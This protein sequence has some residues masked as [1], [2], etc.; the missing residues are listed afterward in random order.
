MTDDGPFT[1]D[2]LAE[3]LVSHRL[4]NARPGDALAADLVRVG[5][6]VMALTR[7]YGAYLLPPESLEGLCGALCRALGAGACRIHL[8]GGG[9]GEALTLR[10]DGS[11]EACAPLG[12]GA[13]TALSSG[14]PVMAGDRLYAPLPEGDGVIELSGKPE[15]FTGEDVFL[16]V[17]TGR[18]VGAHARRVIG[19]GPEEAGP[20]EE[21]VVAG[22]DGEIRVDAM[23][24]SIL[25]MAIEM[26][27]ADRGSILI[28]D[29]VTATLN[30]RA[31]VGLGAG[32]I[33]LPV[34]RGLAGAVF[35]TG[36]AIVCNDAHA[37]IR[38]EPAA[39]R[40]TGYRTRAMLC[41]PV[42]ASERGR[43]GVLTVINKRSGEFTRAD[44]RRLKVL[45]QQIGVAL[46]HERMF[47]RMA[48]VTTYNE[49]ILRSLS[50]G[51]LT[52]DTSG[53]VS[54]VNAAALNIFGAEPADLIG[55]PLAAFFE[56]TLN[57]WL[58]EMI[59]EVAQS[60]EEKTLPVAEIEV[61]EG[62][63]SSVNITVAPL[64]TKTETLLGYMMVLEDVTNE[65]NVRRTLSRHLSN[66][67]ADS[68][69][70]GNGQMADGTQQEVS[71]L[72][73]DIR[74][75]TS[76]TE[77]L[78]ALGTVSMLNEYFSYMEDVVSNRGGMIDKYIGDALMALFGAPVSAGNDPE[79]A[80]TTAVDMFQV[81]RLLNQ[82][83]EKP[84]RIGIGIA[85]GI[86]ITGSIGSSRRQ[87]FT[88]I[89]SPVNLSSRLESLTKYYGCDIIVCGNTF[90]AL[91]RPFRSRRL[92]VIRVRGQGES[93][94]IHEI[95][96]H[97]KDELPAS[98]DDLFGMYRES[99]DAYIAGD[100]ESGMKG[101]QGCLRINDKDPA[102]K[103][104]VM[105]C[106]QLIA[107][108]PPVWENVWTY[109]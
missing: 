51:V 103:L 89:G 45:A 2:A 70:S 21:V 67:V 49:T 88:V 57:G 29:P 61:N 77:S 34:S 9:D 20:E 75:F 105:R 47:H 62:E 74:G 87:D 33:R 30:S 83:R 92:D 19:A 71:V 66:T 3:R 44:E 1:Y 79:N 81:L 72:F 108:P 59:D 13:A 90:K 54:F 42:N 64:V 107:N 53:K 86:V 96:E 60:G 11:L 84:I 78:G 46:E 85:T 109:S 102:S 76:L 43:V 73:S 26:V 39:D 16:A 48:E 41:V 97:R 35:M 80:V 8:V 69:I 37:D 65:Q 52:V 7:D 28:H 12:D 98:T 99:L 6:G 4:A 91:S 94:E 17:W 27:D 31:A 38:F 63:W 15:G 32:R 50:N 23:L 93:T 106:R 10:A 25:E 82:R 24:T 100:W 14:Q 58:V 56:G 40:L 5:G 36:E 95:V 68:L 18:W 55:R 101:F 22:G 104:M